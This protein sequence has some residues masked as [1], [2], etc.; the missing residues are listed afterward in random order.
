[1]SDAKDRKQ[2]YLNVE[3]FMLY[4][5]I[6][7]KGIRKHQLPV[8]SKALQIKISKVVNKIFKELNSSSPM[9]KRD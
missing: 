6:N 4:G 1:M 7:R 9:N 3:E 5:G 2:E 8:Y